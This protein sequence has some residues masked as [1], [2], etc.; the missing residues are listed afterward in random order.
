MVVDTFAQQKLDIAP[1]VTA[2][3]RD[4]RLVTVSGE[5]IERGTL[6]IREGKIAAVGT[7]VSI[8]PG[9]QI[10]D[11][12]GLTVYPGMID[13]ATSLGLVEIPAVA[14][15]VDQGEVGDYNPNARAIVAV[16]PHSAHVRVTRYN[17]ITSVATMPDGGVICGQATLINLYGTTPQEMAVVPS[18]GLVINFPR[19][20]TGSSGPFG[21]FRQPPP[22]NIAEAIATRNRRVE[23]LRQ[24]MREAADYGRAKAAAAADPNIPRPATNVVYES[25]LPA[26]R[27]EMPVFFRADRAQDIR[28]V[29]A[30]AED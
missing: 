10:I 24:V 28:A 9:A 22:A 14:A 16:N 19:L 23:E 13:A 2:A 8:P 18:L 29:L 6:V 1:R 11:G 20:N 3:I 15:T 5:T 27:G 17:G 26:L 12:R 7:A 21:L 4:A 25:L 30:F